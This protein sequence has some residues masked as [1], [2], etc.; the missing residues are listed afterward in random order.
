MQPEVA[1]LET[2]DRFVGLYS[3]KGE[4]SWSSKHGTSDFIQ[5][6]GNALEIFLNRVMYDCMRKGFFELGNLEYTYEAVRQHL[7]WDAGSLEKV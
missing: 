7:G 5:E 6:S 2:S 4:N 1:A 3:L